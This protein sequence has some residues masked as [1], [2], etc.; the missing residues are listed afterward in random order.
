MTENLEYT[1]RVCAEN[2]AG[3]GKF[4]QSS[5]AVVCRDKI[6]APGQPEVQDVGRNSATLTW[7][8]PAYDGGA[9]ITGNK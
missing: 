6:D 2:M 3:V 5:E 8:K 7:K 9:R 4:S 1:F